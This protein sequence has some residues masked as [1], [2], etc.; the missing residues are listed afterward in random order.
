MLNR[1]GQALVEYVLI[2]AIITVIA[3]A[4][5]KFLGGYIKDA[6]TKTSCSI[7]DQGFQ[8]GKNPGDGICV[9]TNL[10]ELTQ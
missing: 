3:V 6:I 2:I 9:D 4:G 8:Q 10:N 5:V 1:K 7:M